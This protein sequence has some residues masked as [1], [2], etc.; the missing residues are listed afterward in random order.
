MA[1]IKEDFLGLY[2]KVGG[3][4]SRPFAGTVFSVGDKIKARHFG[5]SCEVGVTVESQNFRNGKYEVWLMTIDADNYKNKN[6]D[7][8]YEKLFNTSYNTFEEY[9]KAEY[10]WK[11]Q[12]NIGMKCLAENIYNKEFKQWYENELGGKTNGT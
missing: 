2:I 12:C 9:L 5:G 4:I 1:T 3:Y 11:M 7:K 10:N 6:W 8:T